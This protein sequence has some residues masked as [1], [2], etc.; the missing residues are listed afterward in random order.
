METS[1]RK[2][3]RKRRTRGADEISGF[4]WAAIKKSIE[5]LKTLKNVANTLGI[6]YYKLRHWVA[7]DPI[8]SNWFWNYKESWQREKDRDR[9]R[10]ERALLPKTDKET[11]RNIRRAN[12]KLANDVR[13]NK[14]RL[15]RDARAAKRTAIEGDTDQ[16]IAD[17]S[18]P[19]D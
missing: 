9:K 14:N 6:G 18:S 11:L 12:L 3:S 15:E 4:S 8:K 5:E 2:K 7:K 19:I 16:A 17:L 13:L 10:A 1:E